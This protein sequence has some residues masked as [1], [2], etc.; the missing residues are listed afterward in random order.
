MPHTEEFTQAA[1]PIL[2][3]ISITC[4]SQ[5]HYTPPAFDLYTK[6]RPDACLTP[7]PYPF[8][9]IQFERLVNIE[10]LGQY[11]L[12]SVYRAVW[13]D[14]PL[15]LSS[16]ICRKRS[17]K[18]SVI[19]KRVQC[20]KRFAGKLQA[21][22]N[23]P[24]NNRM[25]IY[26]ISQDFSTNSY[27]IV[28]NHPI[29][30]LASELSRHSSHLTAFHRISILCTIARAVA[31]MH[32][33]GQVHGNLH[34]GNIFVKDKIFN[35]RGTS[36][37]NE[38]VEHSDNE[39]GTDFEDCYEEP[40]RMS[41]DSN[42]TVVPDDTHILETEVV[43]SNPSTPYFPK[44]P[45]GSHPSDHPTNDLIQ[46]YSIPDAYVI[47][48]SEPVPQT[49]HTPS[50]TL[51]FS[52]PLPYSAPEILR[53]LPCTKAFDV[54][55]LGILM[56]ELMTN[57]T[58]FQNRRPDSVLAIDISEGLR[59]DYNADFYRHGKRIPRKWIELMRQCWDQSPENRPSAERVYAIVDCWRWDR[60][61]IEEIEG[62][63]QERCWS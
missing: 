1:T 36:K 26:G 51:M 24:S 32:A 13:L 56:W 7:S 50:T 18:T 3:P 20:A 59:P 53:G 29:R 25:E 40:K 9:C 49:P 28:F 23:G 8:E 17:G 35:S 57:E 55:S 37:P 60:A 45:F 43:S 22:V 47:S 41:N 61:V 39:I 33:S 52:P 14:G 6:S 63:L 21:Y 48:L 44:S 5:M 31:D 27:Y 2:T 46:D 12:D 30:S 38:A 34:S 58:P 4:P 10:Y 62:V 54:Y 15:D 19:L 16:K 42:A 11:D